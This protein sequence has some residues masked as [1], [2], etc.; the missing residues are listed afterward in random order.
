MKIGHE[1]F[2]VGLVRV[3][4][5][6]LLGSGIDDSRGSVEVNAECLNYLLHT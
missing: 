4:M 1:R 5:L 2:D 6:V 3:E